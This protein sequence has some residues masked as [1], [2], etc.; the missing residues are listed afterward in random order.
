MKF[1]YLTCRTIIIAL[2]EK[3]LYNWN[4]KYMF[5]FKREEEI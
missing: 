5:S 4:E 3:I 2:T 1:T